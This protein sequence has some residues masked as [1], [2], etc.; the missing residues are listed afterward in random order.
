MGVE[1]MVLCP[2]MR[3]LMYIL[4]GYLSGSVLYARVFAR[5]FKAGD[6]TE[7]SSDR[8]P[9]TANA[10]RFGGFLSLIHI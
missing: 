5:L 10:F 2:V 3:A 8:N 9:G 7:L 4:A 6:L 1:T